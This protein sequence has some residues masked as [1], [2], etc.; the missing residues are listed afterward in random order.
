M[1]SWGRILNVHKIP[2]S[3]LTRKL[4]TKL[5]HKNHYSKNPGVFHP[6]ALRYRADKKGPSP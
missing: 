4:L 1:Q 2:G 6:K 5:T 3:L